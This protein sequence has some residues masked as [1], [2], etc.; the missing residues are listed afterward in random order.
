MVARRR[1][2]RICFH[3]QPELLTRSE[4]VPAMPQDVAQRIVGFRPVRP[5]S[6]RSLIKTDGS[7]EIVALLESS[8]HVRVSFSKV[9]LESD[10]FP[11]FNHGRINLAVTMK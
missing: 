3:R 6:K 1:E 5:Q 2:T 7:V 11:E 9:G 8:P 10:R 4:Q